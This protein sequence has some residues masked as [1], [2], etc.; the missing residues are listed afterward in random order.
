[1]SKIISS[2]FI[3]VAGCIFQP[4]AFAL[5]GELGTWLRSNAGPALADLM[6]RE[7]RFI[8]ES[9][10]IVALKQ[11]QP[12]SIDTALTNDISEEVRQILL[13]KPGI[14][15]PLK[16]CEPGR[17]NVV[18]GIRIDRLDRH[19]HR[20]MLALLDLEENIWINQSPQVWTGKLT[21]RQ[22]R[23]HSQPAISSCGSTDSTSG[24]QITSQTKQPAR[25]NVLSEITLSKRKTKCRGHGQSCVEIEFETF[26]DAYIFEFYTLG[27]RLVSQACNREPK[28]QYGVTRK[29]L[30]IPVSKHP[31]RPSLGFYVVA[32]RNPVTASKLKERLGAIGGQCAGSP[33]DAQLQ[34]LAEVVASADVQWRALHFVNHRGHIRQ[35]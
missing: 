6:K 15:M 21:T 22:Y 32:T 11:G 4:D 26:D 27:G 7:P 28:L 20:V 34:D 17:A 5:S 29:G 2:L 16:S 8:G 13:A 31:D 10:D 9:I 33:D 24:T 1:M 14:R 30:K 18:V 23:L 12:T 19:R 35:I 25:L 3:L